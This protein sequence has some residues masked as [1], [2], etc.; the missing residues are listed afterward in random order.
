MKKIGILILLICF[1]TVSTFATVYID[2]TFNYTVENLS[3]ESSWTTEGTLTIGTGRN[4]INSA[5]TYT[6]NGKT[7]ILSGIGKTL[8]SDISSATDYKSYKPFSSASINTGAVYLSF[9]YK[10]GVAQTQTSSE[11]MGLADGISQGPRLWVGKGV[12]NTANYRFGLTRG[13]TTSASIIWNSEEY[14]DISQTF[15]IVIKYDF[16]DN[17]ASV[18]INPELGTTTEPTADIIDNTTSTIRTKLNNLWIRSQ[19]SSKALFNVGG[20]RVATTWAEVVVDKNLTQLASPVVG[21]ATN[22]TES[23]FTAN[24]TPVDNAQ[25]YDVLVYQG[26]SL[27]STTN[28][29]GQSA[30]SIDIT[31]LTGGTEYTFKVIARGN[32]TDY[33]DSDLSESSV[34]FSTTGISSVDSFV[35]DFGDGTW[36]EIA[37]TPYSTGNYPS[38]NI[39]G[40]N[41]IKAY[42]YAGTVTC[43]TGEKHTN[44]LLLDKSSEGAVLEFPALNTVGE[45]E[46]HAATGTDAMS[47]RFEEWNGT[48]WTVLGTYDTRKTPDSIYVIPILRNSLTKLRIANNTG[49]GLYIYKIKTLTYQEATEL[50]L[51]T[52][53]PVESEVCFANLKKSITLTYNKNI[54]K[55][56]GTILLNGEIIPFENCTV[57]GNVVSI[58]VSLENIPGT[59]KDYTL[60][61]SA[62]AFA[63]VGNNTNLS[64]SITLN[65]QTLKSVVYPSNY[66]GLIDVVYKDVN[67]SNTRM[68]VYYPTDATTPVPVVINMHGG[69]WS[70]GYK[71]EQGGFSIYFDKGYAVVNVEYRL[72]GEALAPACVEDVRGALNYV[73]NHADEWNIDVNKVIFQ[74][75][76]AGAHL[77]LMGGYL[78]NNRIYDNDCVQYTSPIKIMA[79]IDKYGP[80]D[81]SQLMSYSSLI[82]WTGDRFSDQD[83]IDSLSPIEYVNAAT[84]PTYII[85]GDADPTIPYNQSVTLYASLQDAGVKSKFTTVP[86]GGHGGFSDAYNTQME[87]EIIAFL[88]EVLDDLQSDVSST[89]S[90]EQPKINIIGNKIN[91]ESDDDCEISVFNTLGREVMK[92]TNK[93]FTLSQKGFFIIKIDVNGSEYTSKVILR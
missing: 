20:V 11:V 84:P 46:I 4:I 88:G 28:A 54:E 92:T 38:S 64:K 78:Q 86:D 89:K 41:L 10:P 45:V 17:T 33:G 7:Y 93:N 21:T 27:I 85:H 40:F 18:F 31:G 63:E 37:T 58:P 65:F 24:W 83:F 12:N 13:I 80:C 43:T 82:A 22:I 71:E 75:S 72:Y 16:S 2:E 67:S 47:F 32:G 68:D 42:L 55:V 35:T 51:R 9:L 53:S 5:L 66:N 74:G 70:K 30:S 60:T 14:S 39:N 48:E 6:N 34:S 29:D 19:G 15:L 25:S 77:A 49:S 61:V 36:G 62:G 56:S 90:D 1:S 44:R 76:S 52:S 50:T 26:S 8:N 59:N 3:S 73:L 81:F 57:S 69:G 91:I 79:V 23:G 87:E